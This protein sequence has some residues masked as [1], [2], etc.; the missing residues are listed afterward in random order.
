[1]K[2][3]LIRIETGNIDKII[4]QAGFYCDTPCANIRIYHNGS[5]IGYRY[6]YLGNAA[7]LLEWHAR[8]WEK[9]GLTVT[10][11]YGTKKDLPLSG[12]NAPYV[13]YSDFWHTFVC[14]QLA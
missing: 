5:D 1:M 11:E 3:Y 8:E 7:R 12:S 10:R 9:L 13:H 14:N 2:K 6:E 4:L